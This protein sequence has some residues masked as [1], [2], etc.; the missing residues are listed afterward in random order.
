[1]SERKAFKTMLSTV[2]F[3]PFRSMSCHVRS[4]LENERCVCTYLHLTYTVWA[5]R[6]KH[7]STRTF[8]HITATVT[9]STPIY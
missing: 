7:K 2:L 4:C 1:M 6:L 5:Y 9:K 3:V 8:V